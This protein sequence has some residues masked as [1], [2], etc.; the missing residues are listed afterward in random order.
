MAVHESSVNFE[1]LIR[2]LADM[3]PFDVGTVV[4]VEL[5]ANSLDSKATIIHVDFNPHN[6]VLTIMDN[7]SGMTASDFDQYH[8]FAAG[9]KTR[10]MGI[11][12][13]GV[14]AKVS[15]NIA[16]RVITE[17]QSSSFTGGSNWYLQSKRKLIW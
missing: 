2:D 8:D 14:G 7:G 9:L 13:A 6:K 10:G 15:F 3:Y 5:L 12:F 4:V 17:T 16:T 1:N 11:G